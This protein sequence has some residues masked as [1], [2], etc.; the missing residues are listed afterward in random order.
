ML[1]LDVIFADVAV[2]AVKAVKDP[3]AV[4]NNFQGAI[5]AFTRATAREAASYGVLA[6]AIA[7]GFISA[8]VGTSA[9]G[10]LG[11]LADEAE[12]GGASGWRTW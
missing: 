12:R 1:T 2:E 6:N 9:A 8:P 5:L 4:T 10:A 7:P 11:T 3:N